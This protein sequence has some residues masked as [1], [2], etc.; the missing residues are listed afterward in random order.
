MK[1]SSSKTK[2][3]LLGVSGSP[4]L[5]T[6][7][8]TEKV[9]L[10][11]LEAQQLK[12]DLVTRAIQ[13]ET[14]Y[15]FTTN[16]V[17]AIRPDSVPETPQD[18]FHKTKPVDSVDVPFLRFFYNRYITS[19]PFLANTDL[20]KFM[21]KL[22]KFQDEVLRA[23]L[24]SDAERSETTKR[25]LITLRVQKLLV[26]LYNNA[27]PIVTD[28][29]V[30]DEALSPEF[31][32]KGLE[33]NPLSPSLPNAEPNALP[34]V[35]H[36]IDIVGIR[37]I[38]LSGTFR[39][40]THAKFII[41]VSKREGGETVHALKRYDDFKLLMAKL[42]KAFPLLELPVL[43]A[44]ATAAT[45][46][47]QLIREQ[48]RMNLRSIVRRL[49]ANPEVA[50]CAEVYRFLTSDVELLTDE[51]EHDIA[52]RKSH[53][54]QLAE[55]RQ[56]YTTYLTSKATQFKALWAACKQEL[57]KP[58]GLGEF[59]EMLRTTSQVRDLP[60][61]YLGAL[62]WGRLNFASFLYTFFC[63]TDDSARFFQ[64]L[65]STHKLIPYRAL[66]TIL[67]YTNPT[68]MAKGVMDLLLASP[69]AQQ[70]S[71]SGC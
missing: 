24:S 45:A 71:C 67:R 21:E 60:S 23:N 35:P 12:R 10:T 66:A 33:S 7:S 59:E 32:N 61:H 5:P 14:E 51:D 63:T 26:L 42:R 39:N 3:S 50:G 8:L 19:F 64:S 55:D 29:L 16:F 62:E 52:T 48:D 41:R 27:I 36:L 2:H 17:R 13:R 57:V 56:K 30:S 70:A 31:K 49:M 28:G 68:G 44:K 58:G 43:P 18:F 1:S 11:E 25:K 53:M 38:S 65:C 9:Q 20:P 69:S 46:D 15:L 37:I 54:L 40:T 22:E 4:L 6:E 34:G 47:A